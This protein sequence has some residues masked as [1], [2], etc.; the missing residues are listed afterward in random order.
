MK[1]Y[2]AVLLLFCFFAGFA[3][4]Q[5]LYK[6]KRMEAVAGVGTSQFFGDIGGFSQTQNILG[7]KD[8]ILNQT[9]F[10]IEGALRYRIMPE[11]S[12]KLGLTFGM[13]HS[14]D[15]KGSNET[16]G[17]EAT[18][19]FF[20]PVVTGEYYFIKSKQENRYTF[21][22]GRNMRGSFF[23][24]V[25]I[26]AF[27]GIGGLS[28]HVKGNDVLVAS[29][30]VNGGFT[31]VIPVG[32]GANILVHPDYTLGMELGGRYSFSDYL[33]GYSSQYSK[34]NDVYYFLTFTFTYKITTMQN[35]MPKF[36][37]K[38]KF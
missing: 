23:S 13:F 12:V 15:T 31:A 6:R 18:T 27:T 28:Y 11:F 10:N 2:L 24:Y 5:E 19:T 4:A 1:R 16:R 34:S 22:K 20:E 8:I 26:F 32:V 30:M 29:G 36:L 17:M 35:G 25:D 3:E 37:S 9:R 7:L 33:D 21:S 38:R 14:I